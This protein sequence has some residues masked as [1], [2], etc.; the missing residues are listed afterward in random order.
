MTVTM[1]VFRINNINL[2][3]G[4][5]IPLLKLLVIPNSTPFL[6]EQLAE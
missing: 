1:E 6:T 4:F 5:T 2:Q 3:E